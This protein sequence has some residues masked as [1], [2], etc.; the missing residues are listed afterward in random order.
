MPQLAFI[1]IIIDIALLSIEY[2]SL[3]LLD[4]KQKGL[5][6]YQAEARIRNFEQASQIFLG[7][8][9]TDGSR[10]RKD[11]KDIADFIDVI[12]AVTDAIHAFCPSKT[13]YSMLGVARLISSVLDLNMLRV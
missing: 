10:K 7:E 4:C 8:Q 1:N 5:L 9:I 2:A 11:A 13:S 12:R 6:F 3:Y